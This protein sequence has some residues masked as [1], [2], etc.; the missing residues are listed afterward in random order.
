M[1]A[2]F[3]TQLRI[4]DVVQPLQG[5]ALRLEGLIDFQGIDNPPFGEII[6]D[7]G[8]FVGGNHVPGGNIIFQ[9]AFVEKG[10]LLQSGNLEV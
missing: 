9:Q 10:N 6:D 5:P 8:F 4:D 7:H 3:H 2:D 1:A